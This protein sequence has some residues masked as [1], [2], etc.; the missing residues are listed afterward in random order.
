MNKMENVLRPDRGCFK[1]LVTQIPPEKSCYWK[2]CTPKP[3]FASSVTNL[4]L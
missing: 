2:T 3:G 1:L 4:S